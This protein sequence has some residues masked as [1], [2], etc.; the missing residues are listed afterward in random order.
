MELKKGEEI[1]KLDFKAIKSSFKTR[2]FK[3]GGYAA[4]LT[5]SVIA[6]LIVL[7]LLVGQ[8]PAK[9]DLTHTDFIHFQNLQLTF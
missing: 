5:A 6:I 9:L 8:I 2:K 1:V 7:N 3:Y 4:M